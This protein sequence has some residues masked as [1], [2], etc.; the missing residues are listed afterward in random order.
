VQAQFDT[1]AVLPYYAYLTATG[2]FLDDGCSRYGT[3]PTPNHLLI[4]GGQSPTLRNAARAQGDPVW[5][6]PWI[7]CLVTRSVLLATLVATGFTSVTLV[8]R[9]RQ[10]RSWETVKRGSE[11]LTS[12][13]T[14]SWSTASLFPDGKSPSILLTGNNI[15]L[16]NTIARNAISSSYDSVHFFGSNI[17][18]LNNTLGG[19]TGDSS[20][21][22]N[23]IETYST[24]SNSRPSR[25]VIIDSNRCENAT[26]NCLQASGPHAPGGSNRQPVDEDL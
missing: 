19:D 18:I 20:G 7:L 26:N 14:T 13:R 1:T 11:V 15:T 12:P 2:V 24:D 5:D 21:L 10:C 6:M 8:R 4:V 22:P 16:Q 17:K 3:N 23:C 25:Q 9:R